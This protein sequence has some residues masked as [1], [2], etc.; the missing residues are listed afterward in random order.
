MVKWLEDQRE[1]QNSDGRQRRTPLIYSLKITEKDLS[2]FAQ[3]TIEWAKTTEKVSIDGMLG[4]FEI[5]WDTYHDWIRKSEE[6]RNAHGITKQIIGEKR[7]RLG[8]RGEYNASIV[9]ATMPLYNQ[10]YKE[11]KREQ[12]AAKEKSNGGGTIQVSMMQM[13]STDLVPEKCEGTE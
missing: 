1:Q 4:D 12:L 6:V 13:P 10:E 3:E 8:L 2:R 7:E 5:T 9:L 11:W